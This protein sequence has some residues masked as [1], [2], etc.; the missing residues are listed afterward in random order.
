[1]RPRRPDILPLASCLFQDCRRRYFVI[2]SAVFA[3]HICWEK[4][5]TTFRIF[6]ICSVTFSQPP[7][8]SHPVKDAMRYIDLLTDRF[9]VSNRTS[10]EG[11][12][13]AYPPIA[14]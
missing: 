11:R 13:C 2:S 12:D 1:M 6:I 5:Q 10:H 3:I 4:R 9:M 14:L 8:I 7:H